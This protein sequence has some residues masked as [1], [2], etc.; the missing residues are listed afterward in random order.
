MHSWRAVLLDDYFGG[1]NW[2]GYRYDEPWN[3]RHNQQFARQDFTRDN[4]QCSVQRRWASGTFTNYV[5]ITGPGTLF[6]GS[7]QLSVDDIADG[8]ENT[9]MAV[10]VCRT[11]YDWM[12]PRDLTLADID[13]AIENGGPL[14]IRGCHP[15]GLIYVVMANS[16]CQIMDPAIPPE[17][18]RGLLTIAGGEGVTQKQLIE[19]GYFHYGFRPGRFFDDQ[20]K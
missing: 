13:A 20:S 6:P 2:K 9:I 4:Y 15:D 18:L 14:P 10:H 12:E 19:D 16:E 17:I 8:P 7:E 1:N 3:S 11:D 5:L